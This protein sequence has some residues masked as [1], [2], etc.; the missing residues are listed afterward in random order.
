MNSLTKFLQCETTHQKFSE[1]PHYVLDECRG[2]VADVLS[3]CHFIQGEIAATRLET[4]KEKILWFMVRPGDGALDLLE[5][6]HKVDTIVNKAYVTKFAYSWEQ[7]GETEETCGTGIHVHILLE[8]TNQSGAVKHMIRQL[9]PGAYFWHQDCPK[10]Y[11]KDKILYMLG[12]KREEKAEKVAMDKVFRVNAKL[13]A[14]YIMGWEVPAYP[15][16]FVAWDGN[17]DRDFV[18]D[19]TEQ[20]Q[21]SQPIF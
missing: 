10:K 17:I 7:I 12:H 4:I 20:A 18:F 3:M 14:L 13:D 1:L 11:V 2:V 15:K 16:G 9:F 6:K 5:F 8:F 21:T 19:G